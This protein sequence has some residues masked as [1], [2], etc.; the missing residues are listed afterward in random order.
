MLTVERGTQQG[1][2]LGPFL[3]AAAHMLV[4]MRLARLHPAHVIDA[5]LDDVRALGPVA[6]LGAVM[7][8]AARLG[9][10]VDAELSPAKCVAWSPRTKA[11]PPDLTAQWR[12]EGVEQFSIPVGGRDFVAAR[13]AAMATQHAAGVATICALPEDQLQTKLLLHR[14]CAGPRATYA[15][16]SLPPD[17]GATFAAAVDADVQ[18]AVLSLLCDALEDGDL[19]AAVLARAA[20]LI[21]MGGVGHGDRSRVAAAA[22]LASWAD[23]A[24]NCPE[25]SALA[26]ASLARALE[27]ADADQPV[28]PAGVLAYTTSWPGAPHAPAAA[29]AAG[30]SPPPASGAPPLARRPPIIP[31]LLAAVSKLNEASAAAPAPPLTAPDLLVP[32][33]NAEI[34][35]S[36]LPHVAGGTRLSWARLLGG[37]RAPSQRD[38]AAPVHLAA[39]ERLRACLVDTTDRAR[40]AACHGCGAGL[41]LSALPS[42]GRP[43]GVI[44]GRA[45]RL[46]VRLWLG[47]P[48]VAPAAA[49]RRCACGTMVES[50]GV[51]FLAAC[52]ASPCIS[53]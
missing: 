27:A 15:L 39:L 18:R 24:W 46:A 9:T 25:T 33:S 37:D 30:P 28:A 32:P 50:F 4:L 35:A 3:H 16:R 22:V 52:C 26:L 12:S 44:G 23:A 34:A 48:P 1:D 11:A 8:S 21:R 10:L 42:P 7:E 19:R 53:G 14:F 5:F 49:G 20:L 51:H 40:L 6:G 17:V 31:G 43:A 41:W 13:V 45:M 36:G 29:D 38:L 47:M 2:P